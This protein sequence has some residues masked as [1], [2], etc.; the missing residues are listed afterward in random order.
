[1]SFPRARDP[2]TVI[3]NMISKHLPFNKLGKNL[4]DSLS[5]E[6]MKFA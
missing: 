1:M 3:E 4:E 6:D 5:M 2:T